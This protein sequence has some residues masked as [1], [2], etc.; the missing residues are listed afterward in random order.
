METRQAILAR[1]SVR[2]FSQE[3]LER[4]F[5]EDLVAVARLSPAAANLQPLEYVVVTQPEL[6]EEIFGCL[7]WAAYTA[8]VGTPDEAHRP[9]A[10]VAVAV[11]QEYLPSVG[12]DYDLGAAVMAMLLLAQDQG[13][14]TC[15]IHS[16]NGPRASKL[17]GLPP[18]LKLDSVIALGRPAEEPTTVDLSPEQVGKE[19]IRY[20]RDDHGRQVVP[21]RALGNMLHWKR[22]GGK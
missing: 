21:K 17:L 12:S 8:P 3:P 5:L 2:S 20:W 4:G 13:V 1:R 6:C 15:W 19:V 18:E 9:T 22:H 14:G 16:I 7:K 11:R 10:Y